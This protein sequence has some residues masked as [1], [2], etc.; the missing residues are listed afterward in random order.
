MS[1]A[2]RFEDLEIW[3]GARDLRKRIYAL[4]PA[5]RRD[6]LLAQDMRWNSVSVMNG[7]AEGFERGSDREFSQFLKVARG[8]LG[9]LR[10]E[11]S[12]AGDAKYI[13]AA[14]YASLKE[15]CEI[16]A[17]RITRLIAYLES[18]ASKRTRGVRLPEEQWESDDR[19]RADDF[20]RK[21]GDDVR[22]GT[23]DE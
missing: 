12:V 15:R 19:R 8:S 7:I 6:P 1:T 20:R 11:L 23:G 4:A 17:A 9:E 18:R 10:S 14:E 3:Q 21:T 22:R 2:R 13:D 16:L 5:L